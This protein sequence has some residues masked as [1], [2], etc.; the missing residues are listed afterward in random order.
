MCAPFAGVARRCVFQKRFRLLVLAQM[1]SDGACMVENRRI[2]HSHREGRLQLAV[3][4]SIFLIGGQCP[5]VR[6]DGED[7][8]TPR[9]FTAGNFE[10]LRWIAGVIHVVGYEFAVGVIGRLGLCERQGFELPERRL[11]IFMLAGK[12]LRFG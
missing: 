10:R 4:L 11:R 7:I 9:D 1:Q 2:L 3:C 12:L 5:G 6:I 8:V